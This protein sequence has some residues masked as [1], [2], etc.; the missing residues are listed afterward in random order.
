MDS[1][2]T[3]AIIGI[4]GTLLGVYLNNHYNKKKSKPYLSEKIKE[5]KDKDGNFTRTIKRYKRK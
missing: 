1:T 2:I 3:S 4:I 5:A